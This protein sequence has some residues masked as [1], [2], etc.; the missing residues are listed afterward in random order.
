MKISYKGDYAIKTL[1]ELALNYNKGVVSINGLAK[2]GD[3]P[4]KFLEQVLLLLKNGGFVDS[5]RGVNGGYYLVKPPENITLGEVIRFIEGPI[6]PLTCAAKTRYDDCK[7]FNTCV[8]R[9]IWSQVYMATSMVIDTITF[10]ELVRRTNVR[11][12]ENHNYTYA[13]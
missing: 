12:K 6:E 3:I 7:D 9:G 8:L 13:I 4:Y 2:K 5:K 11:Q 10:A 1:L